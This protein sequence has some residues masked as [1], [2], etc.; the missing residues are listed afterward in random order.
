MTSLDVTLEELCDDVLETPPE[1]LMLK[2]AE[3]SSLPWGVRIRT[4]AGAAPY[5][6]C[7]IRRSLT[8]APAELSALSRNEWLTV[9]NT[10]LW[11]MNVTTAVFDSLI[12]I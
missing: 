4:H 6:V 2:V 11:L 5:N 12:I 7:M 9:S 3:K 8:D 10:A 1:I